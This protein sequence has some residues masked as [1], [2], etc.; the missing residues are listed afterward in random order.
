[1]QKFRQRTWSAI[2][3]GHHVSHLSTVIFEIFCCCLATGDY[4]RKTR[5]KLIL[6]IVLMHLIKYIKCKLR[7]FK[8]QI[9]LK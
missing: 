7:R 4:I 3:H 5:K 8:W 1:M 6:F 2:V 9:K